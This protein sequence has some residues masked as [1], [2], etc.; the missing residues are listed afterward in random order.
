[1][2]HAGEFGTISRLNQKIYWHI[3]AWRNRAIVGEFPYLHLDG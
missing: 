3:E 1:M 2:G